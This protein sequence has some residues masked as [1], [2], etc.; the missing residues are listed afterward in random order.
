MSRT[1]SSRVGFGANTTHAWGCI[2]YPRHASLP[3]VRLPAF[4]FTDMVHAR[5]PTQLPSEITDADGREKHALVLT[6]EG[7]QIKCHEK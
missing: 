5:D 7:E 3:T 2:T 1:M 4:L 6:I